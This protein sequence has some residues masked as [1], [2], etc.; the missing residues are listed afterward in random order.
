MKRTDTTSVTYQRTFRGKH[1]AGNGR[2]GQGQRYLRC[3][4]GWRLSAIPDR[5]AALREAKAQHD[6]HVRSIRHWMEG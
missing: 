3:D 1:A 5:P 2:S 4:C 6:A